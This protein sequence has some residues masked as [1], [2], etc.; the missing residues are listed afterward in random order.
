M[1]TSRPRYDAETITYEGRDKVTFVT[2]AVPREGE[3]IRVNVGKH[4][5]IVRV[6]KVSVGK[7]IE[8]IG[9]LIRA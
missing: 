5:S 6:E 2:T 7:T 1:R 8:V 4:S 9:R 3:T